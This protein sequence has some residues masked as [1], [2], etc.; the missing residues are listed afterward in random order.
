M[1]LEQVYQWGKDK[2][3]ASEDF[4][5]KVGTGAYFRDE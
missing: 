4:P 2:F 3:W 5:F 1:S